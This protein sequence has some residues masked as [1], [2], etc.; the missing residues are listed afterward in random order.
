M[1]NKKERTTTGI[2]E[3]LP[4]FMKRKST[5]KKRLMM[6]KWQYEEEKGKEGREGKKEK[7]SDSIFPIF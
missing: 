2:I 6:K 4:K 5:K 1:E 7:E 3:Y